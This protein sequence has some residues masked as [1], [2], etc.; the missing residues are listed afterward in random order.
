[1]CKKWRQPTSIE[2]FALSQCQ[3]R[4]CDIS[5]ILSRSKILFN[6]DHDL[7]TYRLSDF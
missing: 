4:I 2:A 7:N 3:L 1:M 6:Q 5:E